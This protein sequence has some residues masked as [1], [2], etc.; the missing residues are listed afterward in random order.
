[1]SIEYFNEVLEIMENSEPLRRT[2]FGVAK[3]TGCTAA[4]TAAGGLLMGPFGALVGGVMGAVYGCKCSDKYDSLIR[5]LRSM[6]D[7]EKRRAS[8]QI[9]RLVES[10]S[11]EDFLRYISTQPHSEQLIKLLL[12]IISEKTT[13]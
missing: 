3:Q 11:I 8:A 13:S 6:T 4:G 2:V 7:G 10:A 1:M 12:K 5:S 9:Q